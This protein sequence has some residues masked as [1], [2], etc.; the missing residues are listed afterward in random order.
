MYVIGD[1]ALTRGHQHPPTSLRSL[2]RRREAERRADGCGRLHRFARDQQRLGHER[3]DDPVLTGARNRHPFQRG[4]ISDVV[5]R[6][7]VRDLPEDLALS[8]LIALMLPYGGLTIGS[9]GR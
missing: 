8:R 5:R 4:M 7:A 1:P 9:P 6:V 2:C 3:A